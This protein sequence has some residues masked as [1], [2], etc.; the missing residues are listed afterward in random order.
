MRGASENL[1]VIHQV[2]T[3]CSRHNWIAETCSTLHYFTYTTSGVLIVLFITIRG[4]RV[5]FVDVLGRYISNPNSHY[6]LA[7]KKVRNT[8]RSRFDLGKP[9]FSQLVH[10]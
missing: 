4:M 3:I 8:I 9:P 7:L 2:T 1:C 5:E 10:L 6:F